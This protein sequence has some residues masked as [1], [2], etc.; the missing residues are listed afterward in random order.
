MA[1]LLQH[2]I[3]QWEEIQLP[4]VDGVRTYGT[5]K[6]LCTSFD[7]KFEE[8]QPII[9][10]QYQPLVCKFNHYL[11]RQATNTRT[12]AALLGHAHIRLH[13]S[14][15]VRPKARCPTKRIRRQAARGWGGR[16][17][18]KLRIAPSRKHPLSKRPQSPSSS[19]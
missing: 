17:T 19:P 16:C 7:I 13:S 6:E 3:R 11:L 12:K 18:N 10:T 9:L 2:A 8:L 5:P 15:S 4:R 1:P 14:N